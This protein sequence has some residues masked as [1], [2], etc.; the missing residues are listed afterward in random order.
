[1]KAATIRPKASGGRA[2]RTAEVVPLLPPGQAAKT[3]M[4]LGLLKPGAKHGYELHRIVVAHG[5]LY[6]DF[7]K[8]TLYHLL[9][10]LAGQGAVKVRPEAGARGP[11]GERLVYE[12]TASGDRLFHQLM[13]SILSTYDAVHTG[14]EVAAVFLPRLSAAEAQALLEKRRAVVRARRDAMSAELGPLGRES[15]G[16]RIAAGYLATDHALSLMDAEI[17]WMD[18]AIRHLATAGPRRAC[19]ATAGA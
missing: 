3:L 8:P 15:S 9:Q 10:R 13:R 11:R 18:R 2:R 1:M 17:A 16:R 14:L 5:A 19:G 12:L 6:A 7:K 4:V